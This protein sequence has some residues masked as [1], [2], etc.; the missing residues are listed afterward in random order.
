MIRTAFNGTKFG[1]LVVF[2]EFA[3]STVRGKKRLVRCLCECGNE[4][5]TSAGNLSSGNSRSCGRKGCP[6]RFESA[7]KIARIRTPGTHPFKHR[8]PGAQARNHIYLNYRTSAAKKGRA[9]EI[10][11]DEFHELTGRD[12]AYCGSP[13]SNRLKDKNGDGVFVYSGLDRVDPTRGYTMDN[14]VPACILCNRAKTNMSRDDFYAWVERV[15][16]RA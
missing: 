6:A 14:V 4:V 11:R 15:A 3:A 2:E 13:P 5:L 8:N 7:A 12:C 1:R 16:S 9:F 10:S